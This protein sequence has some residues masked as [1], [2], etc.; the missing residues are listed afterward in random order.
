[1]LGGSKTNLSYTFR[2]RRRPKQFSAKHEKYYP[3][4]KALAICQHKIH[5]VG[6]DELKIAGTPI[7]LDV[8]GIPDREFYYLIGAR[9]NVGSE[10]IQHSLWAETLARGK[11]YLE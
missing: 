11:E 3:S 2:P 9:T 1:M 6:R 5:V 7:Y 10:I 8:E 4:L